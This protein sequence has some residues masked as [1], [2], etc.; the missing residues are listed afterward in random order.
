MR[1]VSMALAFVLPICLA[2]DSTLAQ[3]AAA[4]PPGAVTAKASLEL[5]GVALVPSEAD[6]DGAPGAMAFDYLLPGK[7]EQGLMFG[8]VVELLDGED[9]W[10]EIPQEE[11]VI[12]MQRFPPLGETERSGTRMLVTPT[13]GLTPGS[14]RAHVSASLSGGTEADAVTKTFALQ[15][16]PRAA[17]ADSGGEP[18]PV[19][20]ERK[21]PPQF[22]S[23]EAAADTV[24]GRFPG[25][26]SMLFQGA[27]TDPIT[28]L[29]YHRN[30]WYDPRTG[31]FLSPDPAGPVD[32]PNLYAYVAWQPT[33]ATDPMGLLLRVTGAEQGPLKNFYGE[34]NV[35]FQQVGDDLYEVSVSE[36]GRAHIAEY[37]KRTQGSQQFATSLNAA[38]LSPFWQYDS[39][40]SVQARERSWIGGEFEGKRL[41]GMPE[42][43]VMTSPGNATGTF[44]TELGNVPITPWRYTTPGRVQETMDFAFSPGNMLLVLALLTP[45]PGD[46]EAA[47]GLSLRRASV[48]VPR[49][50]TGP[51]Q[52]FHHTVDEAVAPI[53]RTGLRPGSYATPTG[54]LSPLQAHIEL[55]LNPAGGARNAVLQVDLGGLRAAGYE[56]PPVTRVTSAYGMPG[57]GWE[58]RFPYE[59][60]PEFLKVVQP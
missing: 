14:Y 23:A 19:V 5:R 24:G 11:L 26:Q 32:S 41:L 27:W 43:W 53:M 1:R 60:P 52:A 56:I 20:F 8:A 57:G 30:R 21:F 17:A 25:G 34:G 6:P 59:I 22:D 10:V 12:E 3:V 47:V 49:G 42:D 31:Q 50:A 45:T 39:L 46:E 28:G 37:V 13:K 38:V 51:A 44:G 33:M 29:A 36:A 54:N 9:S 15:V 16:P 18:P 7:E 35:A 58:M 40:T 48:G 55:A 4:A 2:A